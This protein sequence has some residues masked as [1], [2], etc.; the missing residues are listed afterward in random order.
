MANQDDWTQLGIKI[1]PDHLAVVDAAAREVGMTRASFM[2]Y[3]TLKEARRILSEE[4]VTVRDEQRE[5]RS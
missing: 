5:S 2:R 4:P 3:A 1:D